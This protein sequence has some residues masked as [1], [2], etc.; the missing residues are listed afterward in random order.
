MAES[1]LVLPSHSQVRVGGP[2]DNITQEENSLDVS[3]QD[4]H[5][6]LW[7]SIERSVSK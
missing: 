1:D 4:T 2:I 5:S 6:A 7:G 3:T